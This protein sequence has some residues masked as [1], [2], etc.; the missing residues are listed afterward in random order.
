MTT[1]CGEKPVEEI[2]QGHFT[3]FDHGHGPSSTLSTPSRPSS[4]SPLKE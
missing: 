4:L 1:P 2:N 3:T